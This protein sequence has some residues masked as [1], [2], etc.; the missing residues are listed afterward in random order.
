MAVNEIPQP[1][2]TEVAEQ[3]DKEILASM[4]PPPA[5]KGGTFL[6]GSGLIASGT[7]VGRLASGKYGI[8]AD[9]GAG[10]LDTAVGILRSAVD[11]TNGD[12]PGNICLSGRFK[13]DQLVGL[14]AAAIADL[15][16]RTDAAL[17]LFVF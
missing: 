10:G 15:N 6:A 4:V 9:A 5:M 2:I 13:L 11:T 1:G 14:T 17:N 8:Y 7:V 12:V 3:R 16:G